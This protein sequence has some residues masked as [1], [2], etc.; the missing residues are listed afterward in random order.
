MRACE[1]IGKRVTRR[2]P[3][4]C[5]Y[6]EDGSYMGDNVVILNADENMIAITYIDGMFKGKLHTLSSEWCD[7]NWVEIEDF[8]KIAELNLA[9]VN[10]MLEVGE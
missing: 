5:R 4:K 2:A 10:E 9:I 8:M 6:G 7:N 3:A 1:L